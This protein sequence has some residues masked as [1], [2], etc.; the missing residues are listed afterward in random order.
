MVHLTYKPKKVSKSAKR[1]A[2]VGKGLCF[3]T[4]GH[5]LKTGNY[6]HGMHRDMT[7]S[8]VALSLFETVIQLGLDLACIHRGF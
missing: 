7:G 1:L 3:D 6:M 5:N 2:I 4:G 8:A